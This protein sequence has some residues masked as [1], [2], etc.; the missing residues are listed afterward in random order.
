MIVRTNP[1]QTT[2]LDFQTQRHFRGGPGGHASS[3]R[4]HGAQGKD[5][6]IEVPLGT[7]IRDAGTGELIRE[8]LE[9]GEEVVVARGGAGGVGNARRDKIRYPSGPME[10]RRLFDPQR[11]EG[12]A[13]EERML[14]LELKVL[15][16]VGETV[17]RRGVYPALKDADKIKF[18][19]FDE[20]DEKGFAEKTQ[21][22]R[23]IFFQ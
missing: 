14:D 5:C 15:A 21:E 3:K 16:D 8:L 9:P 12:A 18:V 19:E 23:K 20:L 7:L 13:G 17:T 4:K 1:Q 2:L 11:M 6:V 22:Y 10:R